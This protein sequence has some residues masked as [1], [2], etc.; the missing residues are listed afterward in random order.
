MRLARLMTAFLALL[1][2]FFV[3]PPASAFDQETKWYTIRIQPPDDSSVLLFLTQTSS[4][5]RLERYRSGDVTQMWAATQPDYPTGAAVIGSGPLSGIIDKC[6]NTFPPSCDFQ[7]HAGVEVKLVSRSS[8]KCIAVGSTRATTADCANTPNESSWERLTAF[9][10]F[11]E[12]A[13]AGFTSLS[14][15]SGNCLVAN[16]ADAYGESMRVKAAPCSSVNDWRLGF[17]ANMSADLTCRVDW[18]WNLCFV[19]GQGR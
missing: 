18:D 6:F 13:G 3:V 12:L 7:G 9:A 10:S 4:G 16:T 5:L 15:K 11:T 19:E 14:S 17:T 1:V 8:G 2:P